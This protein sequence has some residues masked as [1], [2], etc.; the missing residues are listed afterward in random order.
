MIVR[1][2]RMKRRAIVVAIRRHTPLFEILNFMYGTPERTRLTLV[3]AFA[4]AML[5][6]LMT[7]G[8][9]NAVQACLA[10]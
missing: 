5:G 1:E 7:V 9:A 3:F 2:S 10:S 4:L 6:C 8:D